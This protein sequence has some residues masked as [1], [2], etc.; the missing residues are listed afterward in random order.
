[1]QEISKQIA[2]KLMG[3][4]G[5][6][7]GIALKSHAEFILKE[8]GP[9]GLKRLEDTMTEIGCPIRYKELESMKFY[10][11]GMEII[12]LLAIKKA[13]GFDDKKF[14]EI[15]AFGSKI[16][17]ILRIFMKY[18][19]SI[20]LVANQAPNIWGKYYTVGNLK[21][22]QVDADKKQVILKLENFK[23]HPLHCIHLKGYFASVVKMVVKG[24]VVCQ[25]T[26]CPFSG[27]EY[28]EFLIKW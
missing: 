28:H 12:T 23:L 20:K 26:K 22:T 10:P 13:F 3:A 8:L 7:R 19:I 18:F 14:E 1:M 4:E 25:E 24:N 17:L 5:E 9:E 16:S 6:A 21:A 15:G 11:M 2:D 27:D